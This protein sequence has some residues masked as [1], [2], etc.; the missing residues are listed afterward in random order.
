MLRHGLEDK[1][2]VLADHVKRVSKRMIGMP[3][4]FFYASGTG[5]CATVRRVATSPVVLQ[6][7]DSPAKNIASATGRIVL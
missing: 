1:L 2:A 5:V 6:F 7:G 3:D 4:F